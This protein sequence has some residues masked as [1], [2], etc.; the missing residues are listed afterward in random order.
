MGEESKEDKALDRA[1]IDRQV[2]QI[3]RAIENNDPSLLPTTTEDP[4]DQGWVEDENDENDEENWEDPSNGPLGELLEACE[5][6]HDQQLPTILNQL[7]ETGVSVNTLGGEG[8][9]ALHLACLYGHQKCV[10][11]LLANGASPKITDKEGSTPL[12][13]ASAGGYVEI[14]S[15][16]LAL[17]DGSAEWINK[18]D[19]EGD[20]PLHNAARGEHAEVCEALMSAGADLMVVNS[21][22][23]TPARLPEKGTALHKTLTEAWKAKLKAEREAQ[24]EAPPPAAESS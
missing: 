7:L 20:T 5:E 15:K 23:H 16:L 13:D 18:A 11:I 10:E 14:V 9:T 6:G 12:H 17:L 21:T 22:G 1:E 24:P 19:D 8:D 4:N 3:A 2:E